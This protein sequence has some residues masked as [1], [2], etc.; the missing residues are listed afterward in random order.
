MG[1]PGDS[2][3]SQHGIAQHDCEDGG[4][5]ETGLWETRRQ[6]QTPLTSTMPAQASCRPGARNHPRQSPVN[7]PGTAKPTSHTRPISIL[8]GNRPSSVEGNSAA[9]SYEEPCVKF[10]RTFTQTSKLSLVYSQVLSPFL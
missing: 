5:R 10:S 4:Q 3:A 9:N 1:R 2:H 6:Q 7:S 8:N